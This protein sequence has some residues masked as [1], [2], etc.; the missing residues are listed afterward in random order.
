D[1]GNSRFS[2]EQVS[3]VAYG[4]RPDVL[5]DYQAST[6]L[7]GELLGVMLDLII[8]D[9]TSNRRSM[10]D[11]MRLMLDRF[12]GAHGFSTADVQQAVERVCGC[13]VQRF[14]DAHI[15]GA[16]PIA[17]GRY[18]ALA[19]LSVSVA[20]VPVLRDG[21]PAP[22]FR[23]RGWNAPGDSALSL[24][25]WDRSSAWGR[26]GLHSGDRLVSINGATPTTWGALRQIVSALQ[27]G[28]TARLVVR[29]KPSGATR[30]VE[31]PIAGYDQ[32][33]VS[34]THV[35]NPTPRQERLLSAWLATATAHPN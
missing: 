7:Q 20:R 15:R 30:T 11:V 12:G 3:R 4:T 5:G 33:R 34:I 16:Q 19:G 31:V 24:I 26:A 13:S 2:A 25:L 21:K 35:S 28:D 14:F 10:D 9:A 6:H 29:Q 8:R 1:P 17:F 27:I 22:D 23:I 18:L 32:P